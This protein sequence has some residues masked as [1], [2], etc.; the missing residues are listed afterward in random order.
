MSASRCL[1]SPPVLDPPLDP[2]WDLYL[3]ATLG[4]R[5]HVRVIIDSLGAVDSDLQAV[6]ARALEVL[7]YTVE[8]RRLAARAMRDRGDEALALATFL[9]PEGLQIAEARMQRLKL[10]GLQADAACDAAALELLRGQPDAALDRIDQ[11]M[12]LCPDHRESARWSRF[13]TQE[14]AVRVLRR[15]RRDV[16]RVARLSAGRDV[17]ELVPS[18]ATGWGSAERLRR[19]LL[20]GLPAHGA[21]GSALRRLQQA[22]VME[23]WFALASQYGEL[24][25]GHGLVRLELLADELVVRV[26]EERVQAA[27]G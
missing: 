18:R 27:L 21:R 15:Y 17:V 22:G 7:G 12:T 5:D 19:R 8:A 1:A 6:A 9:M 14:E 20:H 25:E 3:P 4:E 11:A 13:L 23:C 24:S 16:E 26:E 10:P 2:W